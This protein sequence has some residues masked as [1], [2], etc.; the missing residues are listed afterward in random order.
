[1]MVISEKRCTIEIN[2]ALVL[3]ARAFLDLSSLFLLLA[4]YPRGV[5]EDPTLLVQQ[6]QQSSR[7][8][9]ISGTSPRDSTFN[10]TTG[11]VWRNAG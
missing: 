9:S 8:A 7:S 10:R 6:R 4:P 2:D 5:R 3:L 11:S 1:M